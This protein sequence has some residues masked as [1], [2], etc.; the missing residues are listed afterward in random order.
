MI[1]VM[2]EFDKE[3]K[4]EIVSHGVNIN[5]CENVVLENCPIEDYFFKNL[6]YLDNKINE[7]VLKENN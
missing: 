2:T 3:S 1:I 6:V 4:K 5:T 7:Y